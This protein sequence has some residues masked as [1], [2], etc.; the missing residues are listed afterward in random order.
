MA[1]IPKSLTYNEVLLPAGIASSVLAGAYGAVYERSEDGAEQETAQE[2]IHK[3][4]EG[5]EETARKDPRA[6]E[7]RDIDRVTQRE[8]G[9]RHRHQHPDQERRYAPAY[10][11][12][13]SPGPDPCQEA[14]ASGALRGTPPGHQRSYAATQR[15]AYE[16]SHEEAR[17]PVGVRHHEGR[18]GREQEPPE[19]AQSQKPVAYGRS[20]RPSG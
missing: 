16:T 11:P 5:D 8:S 14:R 17:E 4:R 7:D 13:K 6:H 1:P 12:L 18:Q 10:E 20:H 15:G 3:C 9:D 19:E 2:C